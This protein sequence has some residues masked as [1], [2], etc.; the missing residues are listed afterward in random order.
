MQARMVH[1]SADMQK[2]LS[3]QTN[4]EQ[5]LSNLQHEI[6]GTQTVTLMAELQLQLMKRSVQRFLCIRVV[7]DFNMYIH[8]YRENAPNPKRGEPC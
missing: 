7:N 2:T 4:L 8:M 6:V 5:Q 3:H 1:M